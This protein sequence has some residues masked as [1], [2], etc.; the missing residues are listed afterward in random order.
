MTEH[1]SDSPLLVVDLEATCWESRRAPNGEPQS[2]TNMEI[3]EFGWM[4]DQANISNFTSL[5][6]TARR[7]QLI[8]E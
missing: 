5:E 8:E 4:F 6:L 1:L 7:T 3:I 2:V